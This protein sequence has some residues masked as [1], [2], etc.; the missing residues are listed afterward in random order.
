LGLVF[1]WLAGFA[2]SLFLPVPIEDPMSLVITPP[3]I[4]LLG[5]VGVLVVLLLAVVFTFVGVLP[6]SLLTE[7]ACWRLTVRSVFVRLTSFLFAGILLG[8]VVSTIG[9]LE[10]QPQSLILAGVVILGFMMVSVCAVFLFGLVL[11]SMTAIRDGVLALWRR[12]R[13][14]RP[15]SCSRPCS[16]RANRRPRA[17]C[18]CSLGKS[19]M[20]QPPGG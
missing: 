20:P 13:R 11:A 2:L 17:H 15:P 5:L 9:L 19:L 6:A 1:V 10:I 3:L 14:R 16:A 8:M 7:L 4:V 12:A 18:S